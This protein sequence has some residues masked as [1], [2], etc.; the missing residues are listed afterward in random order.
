M[1]FLSVH[2]LHQLHLDDV[3]HLRFMTLAL[4]ICNSAPGG[5]G[6]F[7]L[8]GSTV[9]LLCTALKLE[10]CSENIHL[11][12]QDAPLLSDKDIAPY[13]SQES[14]L[15]RHCAPPTLSGLTC[16]TMPSVLEAGASF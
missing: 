4:K 12:P 7:I 10:K 15:A 8:P 13:H 5:K 6:Q 16:L 11:F 3:C 9:A 1:A 2:E 14:C